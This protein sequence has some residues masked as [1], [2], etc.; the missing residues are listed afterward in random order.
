LD[1]RAVLL[2][3][4]DLNWDVRDIDIISNIIGGFN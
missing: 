4:A 2:G 3:P 1:L